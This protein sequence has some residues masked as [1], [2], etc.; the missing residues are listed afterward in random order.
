VY[1]LT[2]QI[3][4][5]R[6]STYGALGLSIIPPVSP[7]V[8]GYVMSICP[9][10]NDLVPCH[11]VIKSDGSIGGFGIDGAAK[12]IE[13]LEH[14]GIEVGSDGRINLGKFLFDEFKTEAGA[15]LVPRK[16]R[17]EEDLSGFF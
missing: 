9:Y 7:R 8:I 5:G 17:Q 14:E 6:V 2:T 16:S 15:R 12:K 13:L 4:S 10:P 1:A 3:P 11:R